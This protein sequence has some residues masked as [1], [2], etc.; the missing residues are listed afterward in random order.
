[1]TTD[2]QST[3]SDL[4]LQ[5]TPLIGRESERDAVLSALAREE[6]RL[7]SLTGPGGIGKTSLALD[8][9][10]RGR[11]AFPDGLVFVSLAAIREPELVLPTIAQAAGI[12]ESASHTTRISLEVALRD[13]RIL[14]ILDNFEH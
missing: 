1:M 3:R 5:P 9:A 13:S 11:A 4:P 6:V 8:A 10:G 14:L 7:V 12:R 2:A